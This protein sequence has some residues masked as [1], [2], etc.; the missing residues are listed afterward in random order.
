MSG[1][2]YDPIEQLNPVEREAQAWVARFASGKATSAD[3]EALKHWYGQSAE[4]AVAFDKADRL[5]ERLGPAATQHLRESTQPVSVPNRLPRRAVLGGALAASAAALAY[6]IVSPPLGLWPSINELGADY[7]TATGERK[8]IALKDV[9]IDMS[10]ATSIAVR[11]TQLDP[12]HFEL[13]AGEAAISLQPDFEG[14]F[15]LSAGSG[16]T[17]A[18][19]AN[20]DVRYIGANVCVTC[21]D[22]E[23]RV[24]QQG[25]M[26]NLAGG[27]QLLYS[28][29]AM[30]SIRTADPTIVTSWRNGFLVFHATPLAE[31][32]EQVNRYRRGK[33]VLM[34]EAL[35][36]HLFNARFRIENIDEVVD[37]IR[38]VFNARV[39]S[40]PGGLVVIS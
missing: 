22:G 5:W 14:S 11:S 28:L 4:H 7:R 34:N 25:S 24:E 21:L 18:Q 9:S 23:L 13:L 3:I 6:G 39:T 36:E 8:Q 2:P 12:H 17:I 38:Q 20:F 1:A 26:A 10:A 19:R 32:I 37:Q 33:I 30:S 40:L 31:A 16:R 27:Q 15:A 35:G 29:D